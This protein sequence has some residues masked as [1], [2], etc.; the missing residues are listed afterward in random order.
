MTELVCQHLNLAKIR[1][2]VNISN[3]IDLIQQNGP[4]RPACMT[5]QNNTARHD[6]CDSLKLH[7]VETLPLVDP[8]F[9]L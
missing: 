2:E 9:V 1:T 5:Q 7:A 4:F 3:P 8:L 6:G